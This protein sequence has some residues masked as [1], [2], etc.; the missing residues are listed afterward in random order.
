MVVPTG[1]TRCKAASWET[2]SSDGFAR[3][4]EMQ[5]AI[6]ALSAIWLAT[7]DPTPATCVKAPENERA[8]VAKGCS[9]CDIARHSMGGK[10]GHN[11]D[12][13]LRIAV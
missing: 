10:H 5:G 8:P 9:P 1:R 6:W 4:V 2:G 13:I 3:I 11:Q 7:T 12:K